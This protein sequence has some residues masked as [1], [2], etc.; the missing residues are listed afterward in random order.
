M[1]PGQC[2]VYSRG[3]RRLLENGTR[4]C[5]VRMRCERTLQVEDFVCGSPLG[6]KLN[7]CLRQEHATIGRRKRVDFES[8][9]ALEMVTISIFVYICGA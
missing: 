1:Y 7:K 9:A 3:K 4:V 5:R 8:N 6:K 2:T